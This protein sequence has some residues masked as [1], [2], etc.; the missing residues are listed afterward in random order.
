MSICHQTSTKII[1]NQF[2][3]FMHILILQ[4]VQHKVMKEKIRISENNYWPV[5]EK[6]T[7]TQKATNQFS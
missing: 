6:Q 4:D 2:S 3:G 5:F 7:S 1:T